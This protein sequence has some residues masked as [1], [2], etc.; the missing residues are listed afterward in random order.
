METVD[1]ELDS[2][3]VDIF[4]HIRGHNK[5]MSVD[6]LKTLNAREL[7]CEVHPTYYDYF[8]N[9]FYPRKK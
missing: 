3:H 8:Y 2:L 6:Y 7:L 9:Q 1:L 4:Q 5:H